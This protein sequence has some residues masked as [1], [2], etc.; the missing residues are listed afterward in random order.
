MNIKQVTSKIF[1]NF[2]PFNVLLLYVLVILFTDSYRIIINIIHLFLSNIDVQNDLYGIV[3]CGDPKVIK[4]VSCWLIYLEGHTI[5]AS[6]SD[7]I[8]TIYNCFLYLFLS[9]T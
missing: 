3:I 1:N 9:I 2:S 4:L 7:I 8:K 6:I 5:S